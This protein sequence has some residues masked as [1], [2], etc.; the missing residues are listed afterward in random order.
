MTKEVWISIRGLQFEGGTDTEEIEIIQKGQFYKRNGTSYLIYDELV[1]GT[2]DVIKNTIKFK[3]KEAQVSKK[4]VFNTCL[5]F[6]E[7][8][9]TLTNYETPYGNLMMGIETKEIEAEILEDSLVLRIE[10]ALDINYEFLA[11][12]KICVEVKPFY[13]KEKK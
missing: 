11:D 12:C 7:G 13:E 2:T 8:K 3:E 5:S 1:E 6:I 4:G 9:K 10:Y